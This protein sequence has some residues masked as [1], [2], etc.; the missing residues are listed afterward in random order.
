MMSSSYDYANADY[1]LSIIEVFYKALQELIGKQN[2]ED[3]LQERGIA[4]V[5]IRSSSIIPP[6]QSIAWQVFGAL[7]QT[8]PPLATLGIIQR[9]G[10]A[11]FHHGMKKISVFSP[12]QQKDFLLLPAPKKFTFG[13]PLLAETCEKWLNEKIETGELNDEYFWSVTGKNLTHPLWLAW[14]KGLLYGAAYHFS[15][16]KVHL[17][18]EKKASQTSAQALLTIAK[19]PLAY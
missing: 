8:Y 12:L 1:S 3:L 2:A 4:L 16:G 13:L 7:E 6:L 18:E 19:S 14:Q 10:R 11:F 15:Q 17:I 9:L 5:Q